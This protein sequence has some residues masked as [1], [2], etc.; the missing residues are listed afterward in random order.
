MV[1]TLKIDFEREIL[2]LLDDYLLFLIRKMSRYSYFWQKKTIFFV[3]LTWKLDK[4]YCDIVHYCNIF[5]C[6]IMRKCG[7]E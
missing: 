7:G 3:S 4:P 1:L 2:A 5:Y 6:F